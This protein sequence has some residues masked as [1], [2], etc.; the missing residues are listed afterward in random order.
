MCNKIKTISGKC[1]DPRGICVGNHSEL[2]IIGSFS[3]VAKSEDHLP[4]SL[5][6]QTCWSFLENLGH[7]FCQDCIPV[8]PH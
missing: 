1:F 4:I 5:F 7:M 6:D 2:N 8:K 3:G